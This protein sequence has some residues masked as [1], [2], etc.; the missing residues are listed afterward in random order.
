MRSTGS[1]I[2]QTVKTLLADLVREDPDAL[3]KSTPNKVYTQKQN[4]LADYMGI[5]RPYMPRKILAGTWDA[6]DLDKLATYF[7]KYPM[8]FV[9]GPNDKDWGPGDETSENVQQAEGDRQGLTSE[10]KS[11]ENDPSGEDVEKTE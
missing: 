7:R 10:G 9:P 11:P 2:S 5:S 8:D 1:I 4:A 6:E 3:A